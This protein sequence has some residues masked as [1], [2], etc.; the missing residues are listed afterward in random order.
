MQQTAEGFVA[1]IDG[2]NRA[3]I[4]F[5]ETAAKVSEM[6]DELARQELETAEA[7]VKR[8]HEK[9][10]RWP[11]HTYFRYS[12]P[13]PKYNRTKSAGS[14]S[15]SGRKLIGTG[16]IVSQTEANLINQKNVEPKD[17]EEVKETTKKK[18]GI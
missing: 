14:R 8:F 15:P 7:W 5:N 3:I 10:G 9:Y 2:Y 11:N 1:M 17:D 12:D 6:E 4:A 18:F 13:I 16:H